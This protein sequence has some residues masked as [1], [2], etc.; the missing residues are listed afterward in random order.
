MMGA[1]LHSRP[2]YSHKLQHLHLQRQ[3]VHVSVLRAFRGQAEFAEAHARAERGTDPRDS[4]RT[5]Q[6]ATN[7]DPSAGTA[8]A[9]TLTTTAAAAA[10]AAAAPAAR[11]RG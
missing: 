6:D 10:A 11:T 7:R 1:L 8:A 5:Q 2:M 9:S 4:G 3:I